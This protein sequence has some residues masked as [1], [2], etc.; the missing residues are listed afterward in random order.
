MT[1]LSEIQSV[2]ERTYRPS[3]VRLEEC[4]IGR[5]RSRQLDR[6]LP[7]RDRELAPQA[8]TYLRW[9]EGE[10][11]LYLAL[12]FD[13]VLITRLE[14][15]NPH[16]IISHHNIHEL[17]TFIEEIT[18]GVHAALAFQSGWRAWDSEQFACNLELQARVDTYW[19]LLLLGRTLRGGLLDMDTRL[20]MK[21]R[22]FG[23]EHAFYEDQQLERRYRWAKE[24]ARCFVELCE[25]EDPLQRRQWIREFRELNLTGKLRFL[26]RHSGNGMALLG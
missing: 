5:E 4:L 23:D 17:I 21:D 26:R 3:G 20:W 2:L 24:G 10:G 11:S 12:Y 22:L 7:D 16:E 13:P 9:H 18:H 1:L 6:R 15:C 19:I 8:R 14:D 25:S